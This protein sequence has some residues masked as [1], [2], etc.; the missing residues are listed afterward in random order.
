MF[1]NP[2]VSPTREGDLVQLHVGVKV[3][4]VLNPAVSPTREG[5]L[6]QLYVGVRVTN[7]HKSG[8][9]PNK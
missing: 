7:V 1:I 2:A 8:S 4:N 5:D 9:I 3:T 6:V